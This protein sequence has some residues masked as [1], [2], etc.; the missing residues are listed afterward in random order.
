MLDNPILKNVASK[1]VALDVR[2]EAVAQAS[3]ASDVGQ[4]APY[5]ARHREA[6]KRV[7]SRPWL[8]RHEGAAI[9]GKAR[10]CF[11]ERRW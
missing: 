5:R 2:R 9:P 8:A 7:A 10:R 6:A 4:N 1:M 3:T 11:G